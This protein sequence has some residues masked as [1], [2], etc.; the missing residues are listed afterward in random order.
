MCGRSALTVPLS[1]PECSWSSGPGSGLPRKVQ[2]HGGV[3]MDPFPGPHLVLTRAERHLFSVSAQLHGQTTAI[4]VAPDSAPWGP[5]SPGS[6]SRSVCQPVSSRG[7]PCDAKPAPFL[8]LL[9]SLF[10]FFTVSAPGGHQQ[11]WRHLPPLLPV[12]ATM[13]VDRKALVPGRRPVTFVFP[14]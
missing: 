6:G 3:S 8:S 9:A 14:P 2:V 5:S 10:V 4:H 11:G 12:L 7:F 1:S 13:Q